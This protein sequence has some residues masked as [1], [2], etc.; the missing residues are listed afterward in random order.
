MTDCMF[1]YVC[2]CKKSSWFSA[3][4]SDVADWLLQLD[5]A[6]VNWQKWCII[7]VWHTRRQVLR[8]QRSVWKKNRDTTWGY[9]T[10]H[11]YASS[12]IA[13]L[14]TGRLADWTTPGCHRRL[15]VLSSH[16]LAIYGSFMRVYLDVYYTRNLISCII[17][18][19]S[20]VTQLKQILLSAASARPRGVQFVTRP[21]REC[22]VMSVNA[23]LEACLHM[24][25]TCNLVSWLLI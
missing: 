17:C 24:V 11:G 1:T 21:V 18:P 25:C 3:H 13:N 10:T 9:W 20:L 7:F 16:F 6:L 15:C 5:W 23:A 8:C 14:R 22:V 2:L 12:R 4:Q 19:H